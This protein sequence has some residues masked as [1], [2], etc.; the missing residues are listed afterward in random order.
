MNRELV[1][2][3]GA[4]LYP[5]A[6]DVT[7]SAGNP[8]ARVIGIQGIPVIAGIPGSGASFQFNQNLVEWQPTLIAQVQI[9]GITVSDDPLVS[10]NAG[11][12][13]KINGA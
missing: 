7:S 2:P 12:P 1:I 8:L 5:L 3:G 9:N 13:I 11:K 4:G 6:G 10:V